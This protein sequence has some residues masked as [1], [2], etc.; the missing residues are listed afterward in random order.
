M[1]SRK[2]EESK[3]GSFLRTA[4]T[5]ISLGLLLAGCG[6]GGN[7]RSGSSSSA[8][9]SYPSSPFVFL[10]GTA[11]TPVAPMASPGLAGF[12]V[13]PALPAG[14]SLDSTNGT[15]SGTPTAASAATAYTIMATAGGASAG[16]S[17]SITVNPAPPS[18]V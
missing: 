16:A 17:V 5:S 12:T 9:L 3:F 4:V 7:S 6:G 14:L 1:I 10:V 8:N 2:N 13:S 18:S 15:I 11:I